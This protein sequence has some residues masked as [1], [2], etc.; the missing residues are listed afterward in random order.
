MSAW[1]KMLSK[2]NFGPLYL[3]GFNNLILFTTTGVFF[4]FLTETELKFL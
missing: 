1:L 2:L 3:I 4:A